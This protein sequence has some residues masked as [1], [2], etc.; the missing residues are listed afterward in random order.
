[1]WIP[2]DMPDNPATWWA[3]VDLDAE[4]RAFP[5]W[6][7]PAN[8]R[9]QGDSH[10]FLVDLLAVLKARADAGF[11]ARAAARVRAMAGEA[12][13]RRAQAARLAADPGKPGEI[14]AHFLCAAL[15]RAL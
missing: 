6:T 7:F 4:K 11:T 8:L 5:M 12:E 9:L 1:P 3:H 10:R 14:N 13:A 2:S 15:A